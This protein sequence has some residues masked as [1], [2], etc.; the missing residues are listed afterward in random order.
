MCRAQLHLRNQRITM[1]PA[2]MLFL[3]PE[4]R[5]DRTISHSELRQLD[6]VA[7]VVQL[8]WH[9]RLGLLRLITLLPGLQQYHLLGLADQQHPEEILRR[10]AVVDLA[11]TLRLVVEDHLV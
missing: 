11:E 9:L 2:V 7:S 10:E 8:Q 1:M 6:L 4:S 5:V 3:H